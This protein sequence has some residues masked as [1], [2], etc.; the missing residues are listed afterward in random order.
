[1]KMNGNILIDLIKS[2]FLNNFLQKYFYLKAQIK[3]KKLPFLMEI[4]DSLCKSIESFGINKNPEQFDGEMDKLM[5]RMNSVNLGD[6]DEEWRRLQGTYSR[7]KYLYEIIN[8]YNIP[9]EGKFME[10][11][12]KF[13]E[14]IDKQ[15]Q[16]YLKEIDWYT[17]DCDFRIESIIVR[18]SLEDSLNKNSPVSKLNDLLKAYKI[19]INIV[20]DI[21]DEKYQEQF[22]PVF[23]ADFEPFKKRKKF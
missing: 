15:T 8:F 20:E 6:P 4:I 13:M 7:L 3:L 23:I 22:D 14:I 17:V 9:L 19:L 21:R 16:I 18:D 10:S 11:I 12:S 5:E 1:M 2:F